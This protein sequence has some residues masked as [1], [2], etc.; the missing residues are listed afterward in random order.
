MPCMRM[1]RHDTTLRDI[2]PYWKI[3]HCTQYQSPNK[4]EWA[5]IELAHTCNFKLWLSG[6]FIKAD[7]HP[8]GCTHSALMCDCRCYMAVVVAILIFLT[9]FMPRRSLFNCGYRN[10]YCWMRSDKNNSVLIL[11]RLFRVNACILG[12]SVHMLFRLWPVSRWFLCAT[13]NFRLD[14]TAFTWWSVSECTFLYNV[15]TVESVQWCTISIPHRNAHS[16]A[17]NANNQR[18]TQ[19]TTHTKNIDPHRRR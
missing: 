19:T 5:S 12:V 11:I 17:N 1:T 8:M 15:R 6:F 2:V 3:L 7:C 18:Q 13:V 14:S 9:P 16:M 10:K 4:T